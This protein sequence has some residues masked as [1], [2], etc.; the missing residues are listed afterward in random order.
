MIKQDEIYEGR[1]GYW[2]RLTI[3]GCGNWQVYTTWSKVKPEKVE[4]CS[5]CSKL[6]H[7]RQMAVDFMLDLL[8]DDSPGKEI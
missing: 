8:V 7:A 2:Y 1:H 4:G 6:P 3:D 5:V